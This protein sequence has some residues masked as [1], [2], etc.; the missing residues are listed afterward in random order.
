[1]L[2]PNIGVP[3]HYPY[4]GVTQNQK[5][6]KD[7]LGTNFPIHVIAGFAILQGNNEKRVVIEKETKQEKGALEKAEE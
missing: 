7:T 2:R 3:E 4:Y 5:L 1:M 6:C